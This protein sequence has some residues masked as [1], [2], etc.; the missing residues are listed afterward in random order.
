MGKFSRICTDS[1]GVSLFVPLETACRQHILLLPE[2]LS[3][4]ENGRF[5]DYVQKRQKRFGDAEKIP[6]KNSTLSSSTPEYC[7]LAITA[8]LPSGCIDWCA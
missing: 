8:R 1:K 5:G 4:A 3:R 6:S 7:T 2:L